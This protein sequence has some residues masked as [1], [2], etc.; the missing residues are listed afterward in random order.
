MKPSSL[1]KVVIGTVYGDIHNIGKDLVAML[2]GIEGFEI[3][4]LG[5]D[6]PTKKFTEAINSTCADICAMSALMTTTAP[7]IGRVVMS[8]KEARIRERVR[9]LVGGAAVNNDLAN[10]LGADG[11]A[12]TAPEGAKLARKLVAV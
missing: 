5:A 9:I 1:G 6:V 8:L 10:D 3:D 2:L 4:D 12:N 11:Y 7:E